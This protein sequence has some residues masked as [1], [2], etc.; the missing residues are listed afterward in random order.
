MATAPA[1][2]HSNQHP[3]VGPPLSGATEALVAL[4]FVTL[5][6]T[7][8]VMMLIGGILF[9]LDVCIIE[10]LWWRFRGEDG[11]G[12]SSWVKGGRRSRGRRRR[13]RRSLK[14]GKLVC[15]LGRR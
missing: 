8:V 5:N 2:F 12:G 15:W 11:L 14:S 4:N 7:T 10:E 13:L 9:A 3:P 1:H 6:I